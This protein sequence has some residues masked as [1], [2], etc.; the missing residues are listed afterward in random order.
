MTPRRLL[1]L[2]VKIAVTGSLLAWVF[3]RV[4]LAAV[5]SRLRHAQPGWVALAF[6]IGVVNVSLGALRWRLVMRAL[7]AAMPAGEALRLYWSSLFFNTF[8]PTGVVGDALRGAWA[9]RAGQPGRAISSVVLDRVTALLALVLVAAG[10]L[11]LP[12]ARALPAARM[13]ALAC[14]LLGAPAALVLACPQLMARGLTWLRHTWLGRRLAA[15]FPGLAAPAAAG[16]ASEAPA[17][18]AATSQVAWAPRLGALLLASLLHVLSIAT[19][20]ALARAAAVEVPLAVLFAVVPAVMV[21]SYVP[22]SISGI[23]VRE[24][25]MVELLGQ[26]GLPASGALAVSLPFFG[27]TAGLSLLGGLVYLVSGRQRA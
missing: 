4:D 11:L 21:S 6:G 19:I 14:L 27:V 24:A 23:G 13:I 15:R 5:A 2:I 1:V 17:E 7:G 26:T 12:A 8:L 3:S 25:A 16:A 22:V 9:A 18:S 20:A 10:S